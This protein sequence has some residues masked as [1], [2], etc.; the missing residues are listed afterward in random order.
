MKLFSLSISMAVIFLITLVGCKKSSGVGDAIIPP[1]TDTTVI[2]APAVDPPLAGTIG[3]FMDD[4]QPKTF[5]A[6]SFTHT[7]APTV[8]GVTVTVDRSNIITKISRSLFSNNANIWMSQMITEPALMDHISTIHPHIIRFPGGSISDIYFWNAQNNSP[9]VDAPAQLLNA[10]GIS[11]AAN[12]WFG[13]NNENWT[14]SLDNYYSMLQQTG[15]QGMITIN[16]GYA[17]YG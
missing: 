6:P 2:I 17:R 12:F 5:T 15:N 8:S 3:F 11:S 4:W 14:I 10:A 16:Y 7:V 9:P 13:K 1:P